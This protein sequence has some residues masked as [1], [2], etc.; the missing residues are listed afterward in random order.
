[1]VCLIKRENC[2]S[3]RPIECTFVRDPHSLRY[4]PVTI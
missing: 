4:R 3:I 1:M 2:Q